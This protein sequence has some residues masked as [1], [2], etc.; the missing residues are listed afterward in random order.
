[1][2]EQGD[3]RTRTSGLRVR[4]EE[5]EERFEQVEEED[6]E[7]DK[8]EDEEE[9]EEDKQPRKESHVEDFIDYV[10][11]YTEQRVTEAVEK[12]REKRERL[13]RLIGINT[14]KDEDSISVDTI[15]T[16]TDEILG[17][18]DESSEASTYL[19]LKDIDISDSQLKLLNLFNIYP[20]P[21]D[22]GLADGFW[23]LY[24]RSRAYKDDGIQKF[25]DLT[26]TM[27]L[28]L[29]QCMLEMLRTD[30]INLRYYGVDAKTLKAICH[31]IRNNTSVQA[32]DLKDNYLPPD[33]CSHLS[34]L[35]QENNILSSLS[36]SGCRIGPQGAKRLQ[37]GISTA[38][39]LHELDLSRCALGDEGLGIAAPAIYFNP[40]L[41]TV[42]LAD[43]EL[44]EESGKILQ[45]L[46]AQTDS[47]TC[48]DLSWNSLFNKEASRP[49]F[50]GLSR[51]RTLTD[52]NLSW[53]ALGMESLPFLCPFLVLTPNLL[54]FNLNGNKFNEVAAVELGK[55]LSKNV[56]METLCLG[57]NPLKALG[58]LTLVQALTPEQSPESK[59]RYLNLEN[60]WANK[61]ILPELEKIQ[62][63]RSWLTVELGGILSN[64]KI[65][66]PDA[67]KI[68]LKRANFEALMP[69]KKKLRKNFGHFILSLEDKLNAKNKFKELVKAFKI[70]LS[71]SLVN[72]ICN[73]F[74]TSKTVVDQGALKAYYLEAYPDT[75]PP[76]PVMEKT[77]PKGKSKKRKAV[78]EKIKDVIK[79]RKTVSIA[80]YHDKELKNES[81]D[82]EDI[83][84]YENA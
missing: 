41:L 25:I 31:S 52:V 73:A 47:L 66:G 32:L 84:D 56:G 21:E 54:H 12:E 15:V 5:S 57:N 8:G 20:A 43:N 39:A 65:I 74:A 19:C 34:E 4:W 82:G 22:P 45:T 6:E 35:Y 69:K 33:A 38:M 23:T 48:L 26:K 79:A 40:V 44:G 28:K 1:M 3:L 61:D 11:V 24:P 36:L 50:A 14:R 64:Y 46:L 42:N 17:K 53:N 13:R 76:P 60:V 78:K 71:E 30:K 18:H 63:D 7:E 55:S 70:K 72:E 58:A 80:A 10:S 16:L 81:S 75:T 51:N 9:D 27:Q 62:N 59:M 77:K 49:L 2:D 68:L 37:N 67:K 83:V 29:I